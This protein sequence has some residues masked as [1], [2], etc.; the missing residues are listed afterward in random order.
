MLSNLVPK[1]FSDAIL[2]HLLTDTRVQLAQLG[3]LPDFI[4][5]FMEVFRGFYCPAPCRGPDFQGSRLI[6]SLSSLNHCLLFFFS[7]S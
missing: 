5:V 7:V 4:S 3:S 1:L 2:R 6:A